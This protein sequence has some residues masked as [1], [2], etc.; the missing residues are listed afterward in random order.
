M[1]A[2]LQA[3]SRVQQFGRRAGIHRSKFCGALEEDPKLPEER[4]ALG[5]L[6]RRRAD[7]VRKLPHLAA[8][9]CKVASM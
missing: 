9:G 6:V 3:R 7:S 2:S 5:G 1:F 4:L 8:A